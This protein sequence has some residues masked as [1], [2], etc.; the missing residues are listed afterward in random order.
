MDINSM[1]DNRLLEINYTPV[2]NIYIN[3]YG[4]SGINGLNMYEWVKNNKYQVN[5]YCQGAVAS[6]ASLLFLAGTKR[7]MNDG[8]M[9]MIH[10]I[11]SS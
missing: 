4:G 6:A 2:I 5:T 3:S 10:Q 7:Y 1:H 11:A 9:M 8:G